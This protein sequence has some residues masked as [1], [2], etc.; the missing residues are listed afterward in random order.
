MFVKFSLFG[1]AFAI[2]A[3][4]FGCGSSEPASAPT[5]EAS[6]SADLEIVTEL[7]AINRSLNEEAVRIPDA[8][9]EELRQLTTR[10]GDLAERSVGLQSVVST[11]DTPEVDSIRIAVRKQAATAKSAGDLSARL[12]A[13]VSRATPASNL[14]AKTRQNGPSVAAKVALLE[15]GAREL[16]ER[17][18]AAN[19]AVESTIEE[20]ATTLSGEGLSQLEAVSEKLSQKS[21]PEQELVR[22]VQTA[23]RSSP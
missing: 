13:F 5:A 20:T 17:L 12:G 14:S 2:V 4:A 1:V 22:A 9:E 23:G 16:M 7:V 3:T 18:D 6:Q 19:R 8:S 11:S 15:H 10:F 21:L